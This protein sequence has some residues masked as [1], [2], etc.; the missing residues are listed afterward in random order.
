MQ[1]RFKQA[2]KL[3]SSGINAFPWASRRAV[4]RALAAD[5]QA[6]VSVSGRIMRIRNYG[7]VLFAQL[8]DWSGE[9]QRCC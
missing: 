5:H 9:M 8:R 2:R 6:S 7:G 4:A 3:Q 1:F